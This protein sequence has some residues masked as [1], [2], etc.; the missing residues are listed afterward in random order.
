MGDLVSQKIVSWPKGPATQLWAAVASGCRK[1]FC[2]A[3]RASSDL[4]KFTVLNSANDIDNMYDV[5]RFQS[6]FTKGISHYV[7]L[8]F[9]PYNLLLAL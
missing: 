3:H 2:L 9:E 7:R 1:L 6:F 8:D 4:L 5:I